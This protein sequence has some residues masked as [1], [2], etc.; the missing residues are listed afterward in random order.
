MRKLFLIAVALLYSS[1]FAADNFTDSQVLN[2]E[3]KQGIS[4]GPG[5]FNTGLESDPYT[6][7]TVQVGD[8]KVTA[9]T[10]AIASGTVYLANHPEA[11][12]VGTTVK[13]QIVKSELQVQVPPKGKVLKFKIERLE[14]L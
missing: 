11:M 12:I 6:Q 10:Y 4:S 14:K 13:A 3:A 7:V 5:V 9:R 1:A 8:M 2:V